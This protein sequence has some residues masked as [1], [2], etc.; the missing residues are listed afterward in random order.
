M[1][2]RRC[3][4]TCGHGAETE[5]RPARCAAYSGFNVA[6]SISAYLDS[7]TGGARFT[8]A[9]AASSQDG[10]LANFA[11]QP[12]TSFGYEPRPLSKEEVVDQPG[13]RRVPM[14]SARSLGKSSTPGAATTAGPTRPFP[15]GVRSCGS[16]GSGE[17]LGR[18]MPDGAARRGTGHGLAVRAD[19]RAGRTL[20]TQ[21]TGGEL[22]RAESPG[23]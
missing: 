1:G 21:Q 5:D 7:I 14:C 11:A 16:D 13:T 18:A 10:L 23:E 8:A 17:K 4:D 9:S 22:P 6:E 15:G 19:D 2:R 12:I 20:P 3:G